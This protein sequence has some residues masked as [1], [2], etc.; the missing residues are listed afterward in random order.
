MRVGRL[1]AACALVV[2]EPSLAVAGTPDCDSVGSP[3]IYG[4]GGSSQRDLVGKAAVVLQN[5]TN[6]IYVVY[7]D[8]G[9]A[10]T[11]INALTGLGSTSITGTAYFWDS[12]TGSKVTCNLDLSG[13][14]V[15]FAVM[16]TGPYQCPLVTDSS[17]LDGITD[18]QGPISAYTPIVAN[19]STQQSISSEAFYLV[20]GFGPDADIAPWNNADP[21]YYIH[22]DENSAAQII[23][24]AATGLPITKYFGVD[25]GSNSN[26]VA[27][28]TALADVEQGIAFVSADVADASRASVR[29]LAWQAVGQNAGYWP[30][31]SA[32]TFDKT[33]VRN[34]QYELWNPIHF[35]GFEGATAGSFADPDVQA[36]LG[37]L[38]GESQPAGTTQTITETATL[39]KNVPSC[40]MHVA[41]DGDIGP[42]YV[43][44]PAEPC[45]CYFDYTATGATTCDACDESNPCSG[46][47]VCRL[48]FCEAH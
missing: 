11:G 19:G 18:V 17:Y 38:S 20:Y 21:S 1:C 44:E 32:T 3:I 13:N 35:Y 48:G 33:N 23:F 46:T 8:A 22:R 34:G 39:N 15:D 24:S 28:V 6:P 14:P 5:G 4:A 9:G 36:L 45:G 41:R 2:F 42:V 29:A 10:C 26:S 7:Q 47:D 27:Y 37:Y 31:S 40:A 25:A 43:S 30:D 12:A 16:G